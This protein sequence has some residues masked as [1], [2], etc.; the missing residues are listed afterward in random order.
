MVDEIRQPA[1][2]YFRL[3]RQIKDLYGLSKTLKKY[4]V[5]KKK[6]SVF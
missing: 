3:L 2:Y 4:A 1:A 5:K 6:S